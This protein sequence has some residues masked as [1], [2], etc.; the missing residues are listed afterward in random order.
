MAKGNHSTSSRRREP[1]WRVGGSIR[2]FKFQLIARLKNSD[3]TLSYI[4]QTDKELCNPESSQEICLGE[5]GQKTGEKVRSSYTVWRE[6]E[7]GRERERERERRRRGRRRK[8]GG[9]EEENEAEEEKRVVFYA[10]AHSGQTSI[11]QDFVVGLPGRCA[12]SQQTLRHDN[13]KTAVGASYSS[14]TI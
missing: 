3:Y 7:K 13:S 10:T 5:A 6:R 2:A 12:L 14:V 9:E 11:V 4:N 1:F 8:G